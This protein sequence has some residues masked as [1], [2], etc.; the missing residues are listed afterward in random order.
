MDKSIILKSNITSNDV[1]ILKSNTWGMYELKSENLEHSRFDDLHGLWCKNT[2]NNKEILEKCKQIIKLI[3][4]IE[5]LN[6]I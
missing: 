4:E 1:Y 5:D 2:G 6:K 3:E